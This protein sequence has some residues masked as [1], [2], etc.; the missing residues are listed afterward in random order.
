MCAACASAP[1][2]DKKSFS[3]LKSFHVWEV[4]R[5]QPEEV[6]AQQSVVSSLAEW[7]NEIESWAGMFE[8]RFGQ[9]PWDIL[10]MSGR[11]R[12]I[13][14]TINLWGREVRHFDSL[15][16]GDNTASNPIFANFSNGTLMSLVEVYA[17]RTDERID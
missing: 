16:R 7:E 11:T 14:D 17:H 15:F 9:K 10:R 12:E 2:E 5:F 4:R 8:E 1:S 13:A 6:A 3:A